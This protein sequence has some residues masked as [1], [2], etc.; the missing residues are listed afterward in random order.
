M[1][2]EKQFMMVLRALGEDDNESKSAYEAIVKECA[3]EGVSTHM[4]TVEIPQGA[5]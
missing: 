2:T 5:I 3:E 4:Q 1:V